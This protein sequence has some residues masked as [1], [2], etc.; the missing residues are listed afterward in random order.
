MF[1]EHTLP[2]GLRVVC[3]RV[4]AVSSIALGFLVRTGARD[5]APH[6]H[7][8]SHY[9]E[10]MCFKGT[11]R[12]NWHDINVRFDELGSIYNAFTG[13]EHTV[14]YGWVPADRFEPQLELLADMMR[15]ALPNEDFE[16]ERN[17]ILE[18]IAM[19]DDSFDRHVSYFLHRTVFGEHPLAHEI[20]GEKETIAGL[21]RDTMAAYHAERY[22]PENMVLV[23]SG[24]V[25]PERI[26][27]AAA[28][29]CG[30]W[31]RG[32]RQQRQRAAPPKL[33]TGVHRLKLDRFRQQSVIIA[34]PSVRHGT[35]HDASLGALGALF[36]GANSRCYW[37]I[38][39]KG[40]C[41]SAGVAWLSYADTGMLAF[42]ADG[43]PERAEEMHDALRKEIADLRKKGVRPDEVERV[44]NQRRTQLALESES[45]RTRFM[46]VIDDIEEVARPR[47]VNARLAETAAVSPQTI[48]DYFREYPIDGDGM[49]LSCGARE[50]P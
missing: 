17:V 15:P 4:P 28:R 9:L 40:I 19:N 14:Y 21:P 16:T 3:E 8:V 1:C 29:A 20:L 26:F 7:G 36:G 48:A 23:A 11:A 46:Q 30:G 12:R 47:S 45:P 34:Y 42:Y 22:T 5:E 13:K 39:Q 35:K 33:G 25:E 18:E 49:L 38:V 27:A 6:E 41:S 43:E 31:A 10:H 50:W 44:R 2:N 24:A 32:R 37:H